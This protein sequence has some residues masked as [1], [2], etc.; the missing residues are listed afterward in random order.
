MPIAEYLNERYPESAAQRPTAFAEG[1]LGLQKAFNAA[2]DNTVE[3]HKLFVVPAIASWLNPPSEE[4]FRRTRQER[5]KVQV[6]EDAIPKAEEAQ[7]KWAKFQV[8]LDKVASWYPS[9][10]QEQFIMGSKPTWADIVVA[11]ELIW[12]KIVLGAESEKWKDITR[13]HSE[14]WKNVL[15]SMDSFTSTSS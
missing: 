8:E 1:T 5:F 3:S 10:K 9:D 7:V 2:F 14:R 4:H 6:V 15:D 12:M 11:S 13:W